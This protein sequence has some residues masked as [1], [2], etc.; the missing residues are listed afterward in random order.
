MMVYW[1]EYKKSILAGM[2]EINH[3]YSCL[4]CLQAKHFDDSL[5]FYAGK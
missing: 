1:C 4:F 2:P 5:S 3:H